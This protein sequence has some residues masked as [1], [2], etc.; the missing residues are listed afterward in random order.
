MI[1]TTPAEAQKKEK[2]KLDTEFETFWKEFQGAV[3]DGNKIK[4]SEM[5][6]FETIDMQKE[7]FLQSFNKIEPFTG[8]TQKQIASAK[9]SK[10][11]IRKNGSDGYDI[12]EG[13]AKGNQFYTLEFKFGESFASTTLVFGKKNNK[14]F[15][16]KTYFETFD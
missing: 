10:F 11:A 13:F 1:L 6:N 7:E 3:K 9:N 16:I 14:Y 12:I 4:L 2:V 5:I 8:I 15:L